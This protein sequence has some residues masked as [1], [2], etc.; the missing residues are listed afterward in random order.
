MEEA[1]T[2]TKS[3]PIVLSDSQE[4]KQE[5]STK[6]KRQDPDVEHAE[7]E[8]SS[9][10]TE[11]EQADSGQ[12]VLAKLHLVDIL[13]FFRSRSKARPNRHEKLKSVLQ[14]QHLQAAFIIVR[15]STQNML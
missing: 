14:P 2:G 1:A 10:Q 7:T 4:Y 3:H 12:E 5:F 11:A 9:S 6:R 13:D 15:A 8:P